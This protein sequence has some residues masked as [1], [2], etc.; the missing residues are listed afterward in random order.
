MPRQSRSFKLRLSPAGMDLL[1]DSH[2][3]LIRST[4][5]LLAWGTTL[6]V[7]VDHLDTVP[8]SIV[9]E[10]LALLPDAGLN[11][12][13]EHH[14]GAPR[15]LNVTAT[16]IAERVLGSAPDCGAPTLASIYIVALQQLTR[17]DYATLRATYERARADLSSTVAT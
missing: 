5:A 11:G 4:R 1:I 6:K 3:H 9:A 12:E 16:R 17:A 14:V 15:E 2:C 10:K 8:P 7:A 13:E